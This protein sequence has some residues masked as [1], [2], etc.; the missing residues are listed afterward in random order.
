M[1]M[2]ATAAMVKKSFLFSGDF[3]YKSAG[4]LREC[5]GVEQFGS[6]AEVADQCL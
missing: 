2:T 5:E 6:G 4:L 3:V 1:A